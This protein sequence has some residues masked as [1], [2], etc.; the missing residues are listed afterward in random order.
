MCKEFVFVL[1]M[2]DLKMAQV[3]QIFN[4]IFAK[5][6]NRYLKWLESYTVLSA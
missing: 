2:W 1:E 5:V 3:S 6:I 4:Q